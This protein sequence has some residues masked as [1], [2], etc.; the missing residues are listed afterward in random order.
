MRERER[1]R[2][3]GG[4]QRRQTDSLTDWADLVGVRDKTVNV[5]TKRKLYLRDGSA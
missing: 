3:W 5:R 4:G 1:E 2:E